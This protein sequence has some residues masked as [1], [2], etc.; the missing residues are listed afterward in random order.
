MVAVD[1]GWTKDDFINSQNGRERAFRLLQLSTDDFDYA[2]SLFNANRLIV[3]EPEE[4][5]FRL[6]DGS[7][8]IEITGREVRELASDAPLYEM[9]EKVLSAHYSGKCL[10]SIK[11]ARRPAFG[12]ADGTEPADLELDHDVSAVHLTRLT[13]EGEKLNKIMLGPMSGQPLCLAPI[14]DLG[15]LCV[16]EGIENALT[17][18]LGTGLGAWAAGAANN[19]PKLATAMSPHA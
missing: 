8:S 9:L 5:G 4:S 12:L 6:P 17:M 3:K 11:L 10:V 16:T 7:I 2:I 15:G 18:H 19:L 1:N 14:N 13:P